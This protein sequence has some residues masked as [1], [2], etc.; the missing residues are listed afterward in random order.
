MYSLS[1]HKNLLS[2]LG[3]FYSAAI[4][5]TTF[6]IVKD[7][8]KDIDPVILVGYRFILAAILLCGFCIVARKPLFR[9]MKHGFLSGLVL[10]LLYISQTVG[11]G[12]TTASNSGFIT[13]LFVAFVPLYSLIIFKKTPLLA[14][15]VATVVSIFGLWLLT[16]GL[17]DINVGDL[18]T[19]IAAATYALHILI[20]DKYVKSGDDP[21]L[22]SFQQFMFV[23]AASLLTGAIFGLPFSVAKMQTT[24]VILFLTVFP[25]LSAFVIQ[26][27]AQKVTKPLRVSLILAF[28]PVFAGLF[29]WTLGNE[30]IV[31]HRAIGGFFIFLGMII[32]GFQS[33]M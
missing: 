24:W 10:W 9:N 20:L 2:E 25:T 21:Y 15:I 32:S 14:E 7:A 12:I 6:F 13:G 19:L 1:K 16:G 26:V 22:L 18:F 5:G 31:F 8:L 11:L 33:K 27:V 23:G 3:L 17:T 28:E 29:A 30:S 4:W